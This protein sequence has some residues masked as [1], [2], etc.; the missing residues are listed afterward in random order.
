MRSLL[1][2]FGGVE[3]YSVH[4]FNQLMRGHNYFYVD[5][6]MTWKFQ[7]AETIMPALDF[8]FL[9]IKLLISFLHHLNSNFE[10]VTV[11]LYSSLRLYRLLHSCR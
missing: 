7:S 3:K 11:L 10:E 6:L 1:A 8:F 2:V 5:F 9:N 4:D